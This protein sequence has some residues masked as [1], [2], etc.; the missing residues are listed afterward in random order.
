MPHV[1]RD[2]PRPSQG[3]RLKQLM[4]DGKVSKIGLARLLA[5]EG[6]DR[7][8]VESRRRQLLGWTKPDA[9]FS[10]QT[11]TM[12]ERALNAPPGAL[13]PDPKPARMTTAR[14]LREALAEIAELHRRVE[15][16]EK[17][18]APEDQQRKLGPSA[19]RGSLRERAAGS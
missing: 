4:A 2:D 8:A 7:A 15:L 10:A 16:L 12:L 19:R 14:A 9:G 1:T 17:R 18:L 13:A 5:G 3:A 11:A 6:A